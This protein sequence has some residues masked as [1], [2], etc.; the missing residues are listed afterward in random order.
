MGDII[1]L[2]R[3][4]KAVARKDAATAANANRLRFGLTKAERAQ[5][6]DGQQRAARRLDGHLL[7]KPDE[8]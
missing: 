7:L 5:A 4:R 2:K 6:L 3:V 1:N 8:S